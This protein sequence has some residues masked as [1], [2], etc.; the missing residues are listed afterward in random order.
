MSRLAAFL[1]LWTLLPALHA[2][3]DPYVPEPLEA[4][5]PWVLDKQ[6]WRECPTAHGDGTR[7]CAWPGQLYLDLDR[8]GGLFAQQW[9]LF[10]ETWVP[11]PGNGDSWP[12][13]V[14][15]DDRPI[16]V[17]SREGQPAVWLES[18]S[19]AL[20]GR[21]RWTRRPDALAVSPETGLVSL[22]LDG[23]PV[24]E[25]RVESG[26]RLWIGA[27]D[28]AE[29]ATDGD[30]LG[31]VVYRLIDD[32]LPL[33]VTTR[34]ELDVSGRARQI[35][36][37]P[38][39]LPGG[40]PLRVEAALPS[41]LDLD[42][43]L[44]LQV[45]PGHWVVEIAEYHAGPVTALGRGV[46]A[47][48]WPTDE[49]WAFRSH[50]D[51][52]QV[53]VEG[54]EPIDPRQT[55]IPPNWS[56]LPV[57][58]VGPAATMDL[59]E[60]RRGD[61]DPAPD[62]LRLSRELWLD[63]D[64]GGYSV[65]D[66]IAG[67]LTRS[68]RLEAAPGLELGQVRIDGQPRL[69]TRLDPNASPGVEVRRGRLDLVADSRL[70][71]EPDRVPASG[72]ALDFDA[73]Q[74]QL[75]LPPGWD[76]L[77]ASGV[78]NLP[79]SWIARWTLLDLFLVLILAL[80]VS[81]L[82]GLGWGVL[83]L[84]ALGLTWQVPGA[85]RLVWLN[86]LAGAALLRLL[87]ARSERSGMARLRG[88]VS[89]YFRLTL[90]ALLV[91][92]LPFLVSHVRDGLYPHL[93]RSWEG[94][95]GPGVTRPVPGAMSEA[96]TQ[97][98]V[99][100]EAADALTDRA[101]AKLGMGL[102]SVA[103]A[104]P[105]PIDQIDP[106]A[107]VQS[108]P[109]IPD[110]HWNSFELSW[111]GP[112]DRGEAA[113]LWL[114]GPAMRLA[115]ALLG[116]LLLLLLALR[117]SGVI[118][119]APGPRGGAAGLLLLA[120][121]AAGSSALLGPSP[122]EAGDLPTQEI[123]DQ[124]QS[125]LLAPPDCLPECAEL[126]SLSLKAEPRRLEL[127]LTLDTADRVAA[128]V[129]GG[130]G[131]W[132]PTEVSVDGI[133]LDQLRRGAADQLLV[134]L[135]R[136]RHRV[137]LAGPLPARNQIQITLPLRPR[138][139]EIEADG[140]SVEGLDGTG[141]PGDQIQLVRLSEQ[142]GGV[143]EALTQGPLPPLLRVERTLR[144]GV[145]WR[146][147]SRVQRLSAPEFPA[148]LPVPLLPGESVQTA[149]AQI[150]DGALLVSL[151]PG[152]N[153]SGWAS[154]LEP[155]SEVVLTASEDPRVSEEWRLDPSPQWH[156]DYDGI[157]AVHPLGDADRWLPT[158][159]PRPG[160]TLALRFTR[161]AAEPGPTLTIDRVGYRVSPGRRA[162]DAELTL[163]LRSTQGGSHRIGLPAG[164]EPTRI[165][166]DGRDLP[167]PAP[168]EAIELPL[169]PGAQEASLTWREPRPLG[170]HFRPSTPDL[171]STAVNLNLSLRMPDDRWIL[172]TGGPRIG[173]VVLFW[174]VL[175]VVAALAIVLGRSRV[176][177][178]RT[179]DW[180]LLGIGLSL[181]EI[182]VVILI[183]GWLF[184]L[185]LRRR[186]DE[187]APR[188]RY[189]LAQV[190]LMLLTIVALG[191]LIGAVQQ[192]L[193]GSPQMQIRGNGSSAAL[194]S[195]YQDRGGPSLPEVWAVSLPMLAYRALMLA[196]S[197]WLA[198]RLLDWLRWG[199]EGF[200]RPVMWRETRLRGLAGWRR[201]NDDEPG[202]ET[203]DI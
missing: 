50:P 201:R 75:N 78:D 59:V 130:P 53:E 186:L 48:P 10:A 29:G 74:A 36:T 98:D 152:T 41:R 113:R 72:W 34:L 111:S 7:L 67:Q 146:V 92:G 97:A 63:S 189:N 38:A 122:A 164:A 165:R 198:F 18:G 170:L 181:S 83:A 192:G 17:V 140:W 64:G 49:I 14:H 33:R 39:L 125:R 148:L 91:I 19:H 185:G 1:L 37:G 168:G 110:W 65:Q 6:D 135:D 143:E 154:T 66:R 121:V 45:R 182:W 199:W 138:H 159:R 200:S 177:P 127:V 22:V 21:F 94:I 8:E 163:A 46:L 179:H 137:E 54:L 60:Q 23:S 108:G 5:V 162:T 150:R 188:G 183:V 120:W 174:G 68:W 52:R 15:D 47:P 16:P 2:G 26:G 62:R 80:G 82:W 88:L 57:Y 105:P 132:V 156:L 11:L 133:R 100:F 30:R 31:L 173:P 115:M 119:R 70:G 169:V 85:P 55:G 87:P 86:L 202:G 116:S 190:G 77:A 123:L 175:L 151:A 112:A 167:L 136:G 40:T 104:P 109:G 124:L 114:I 145:D 144:V 99:A 44:H 118:D 160:E 103:P 93:E 25:P 180:L 172:F 126:S 89:W 58:R 95:G 106:D 194:L 43:T 107:R 20:S 13:D 4:W 12:L 102:P 147:E 155:V 96:V 184:A 187:E 203:L 35:R 161:P 117:M 153:E 3:P 129:P 139:L 73:V 171:G 79:D 51:L 158:W 128:P 195:W 69:I 27:R 191:A 28:R 149:G 131:G 176:T 166:L 193:L 84:L 101:R 157:P 142:G 9:Q 90:L 71:V 61:P 56:R 42:G 197:L 141:R 196:W 178:L 24:A 134:A 32:D 76:L 81:R